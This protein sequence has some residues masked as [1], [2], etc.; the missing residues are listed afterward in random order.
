LPIKKW[1]NGYASVTGFYN[2]Y[3]SKFKEYDINNDS[4]SV[5]AY[6]EHSFTLPKAWT[7]EISGSYTSQMY[8]G[9]IKLKPQGSMDLGFSK[10]IN[11][12][13]KLKCSIQDVF[14][15]NRT[16][17]SVNDNGLIFKLNGRG[18]SR[19]IR[20][21]YSYNFGNQQV[22][23]ARERKTATAEEMGRVKK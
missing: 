7:A 6:M 13:S 19:Q 2:S 15:T 21:T 5:T 12:R 8:W 14:W 9:V 23:T 4:W 11:N 18:E 1:W 16:R 3:K 20:L 17:G 10:K 22:K